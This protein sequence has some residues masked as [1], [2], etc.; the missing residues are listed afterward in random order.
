LLS[1]SG[2]QNGNIWQGLLSTVIITA[3]SIIA[4]VALGSA[5]A[6]VIARSTRAWSNRAYYLFL[7]AIV[8]PTSLARC[9]CTSGLSTSAWSATPGA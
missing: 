7:G 6:Y 4:L 8:L 2:G 9:R 1:P 5:A 3:G